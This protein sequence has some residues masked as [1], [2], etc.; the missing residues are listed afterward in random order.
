M[1]RSRSGDVLAGVAARSAEER[2]A[3]RAVLADVPLA[4]FLEE[5]LVP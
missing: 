1:S 5:P 3:A 4:R 2:V